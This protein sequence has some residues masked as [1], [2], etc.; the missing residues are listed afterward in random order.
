MSW[1]AI[2]GKRSEVLTTNYNDSTES[3]ADD[4]RHGP[5]ADLG[6]FVGG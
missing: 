1:R 4:W 6:V 5:Q 3:T 2:N